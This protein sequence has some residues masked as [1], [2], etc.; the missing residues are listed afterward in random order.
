MRCFMKKYFL[1][2]LSNNIDSFYKYLSLHS[3]FDHFSSQRT[4]FN[5]IFLLKCCCKIFLEDSS[6]FGLLVI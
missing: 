5:F 3:G 6:V 2:V 4:H 1:F